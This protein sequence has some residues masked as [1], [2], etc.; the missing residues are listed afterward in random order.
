MIKKI[1]LFILLLIIVSPALSN[2]L[3]IKGMG[4]YGVSINTGC[5]LMLISDSYAT[6][7]ASGYI[8]ANENSVKLLNC[9]FGGTDDISY[10]GGV[11]SWYY[12]NSAVAELGIE[13][14]RYIK[15]YGRLRPDLYSGA[16]YV[17]YAVGKNDTAI[18][19]NCGAYADTAALVTDH[20]NFIDEVLVG[21]LG[22]EY[23]QIILF[24]TGPVEVVT[25][26][27]IDADY[28]DCTNVD[29]DAC[30]PQGWTNCLSTNKRLADMVAAFK[31]LSEREGQEMPFADMWSWVINTGYIPYGATYNDYFREFK[32]DDIH[33]NMSKTDYQWWK[34]AVN[35]IEDAVRHQ[36]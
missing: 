23:N 17:L 35:I 12:P 13:N 7:Y 36:N 18:Q 21:Q 30:I 2:A 16:D 19:L 31:T 33:V 24:F 9:N 28:V 27:E 25:S 10:G 20:T 15:P 1:L 29:E 32:L 8:N 26:G 4:L 3:L 34:D 22:Y 11:A 6:A 14:E 5:S